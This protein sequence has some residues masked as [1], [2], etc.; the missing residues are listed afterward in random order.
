MLP[1]ITTS[2]LSRA[3][4]PCVYPMVK[5]SLPPPPTMLS[6]IDND[7]EMVDTGMEPMPVPPHS[8]Q[9]SIPSVPGASEFHLNTILPPP[10]LCT[11]SLSTMSIDPSSLGSSTFSIPLPSL[12]P[13]RPSP[14]K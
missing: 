1:P 12:L 5:V 2:F 7:E 13:L 6:Y 11:S 14:H 9:L 10:C 4:T 3:P 8:S